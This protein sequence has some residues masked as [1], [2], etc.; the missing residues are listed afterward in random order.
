MRQI[1]RINNLMK[2]MVVALDL[3]VLNLLISL[4]TVVGIG[5]VPEAVINH[6][7]DIFI[8]Y[9]LCYLFCVTLNPP[10]LHMYKVRPDEIVRK[11]FFTVFWFAVLAEVCSGFIDRS[12][13]DLTFNLLFF[14]SLGVLV[15]FSRLSSRIFVK[16]MRK[17]GRNTRSVVFVGATSN[18]IELYHEMMGDPAF[19]YR[20]QGYFDDTKSPLFPDD[21]PWLGT[22]DQV[23]EYL[24]TPENQGVQYLYCC[25]PSSREKEIRTIINYCENHV[26]RFFSVPNVR[27][28][29]KRRMNMELL[30]DV[31]ILYIREEPLQQMDNRFVK[32]TFDLVCS[33]LFLCT[34]F[35]IIYLVVAVII[36]ITSP[37]PIFFR[38]K[39]NGLDGR[40]FYC[41]K[42]RSMKVNKL[43]EIGRAHV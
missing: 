15:M 32:R 3:L 16:N 39:R 8:V 13:L 1:S 11:V 17:L 28:Y 35:P 19:G 9:N 41:Y 38:Q 42:F 40:E 31:P 22:I 27:N 36:K 25:L 37:G 12:M 26:V 6:T 30:G 2:W 4:Y 10:I 43:A 7:R 33:S 23:T 29:L 5:F 18:M 21:I 20:L 34:F 14:I 24:D